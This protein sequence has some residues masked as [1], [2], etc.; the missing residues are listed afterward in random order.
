MLRHCLSHDTVTFLTHE[1]QEC[2]SQLWSLNGCS[3]FSS[4][5]IRK[6]SVGLLGR[7]LFGWLI[8]LQH[9]NQSIHYLVMNLPALL[10]CRFSQAYFFLLIYILHRALWRE[11][12]C[13]V[14]V[15]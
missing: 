9:A 8:T 13:F 6:S 11:D 2:F 1:N 7:F 5:A 15:T 14:N 3:V 4:F 10:C 12:H